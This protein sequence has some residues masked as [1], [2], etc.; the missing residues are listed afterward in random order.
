MAEWPDADPGPVLTAASENFRSSL[1]SPPGD[2][3]GSLQ[4]SG[5]RMAT[6]PPLMDQ[7]M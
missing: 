6:R 5:Y 4:G 7:E 2:D 3:Y 1:L